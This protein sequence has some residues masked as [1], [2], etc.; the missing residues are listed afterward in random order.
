MFFHQ[1]WPFAVFASLLAV[2]LARLAITLNNFGLAWRYRSHTPDPYRLNAGRSL[3]MFCYEFYAS[4][5]SS[6]WAMPF[7]SFADGGVAHSKTLPV[8]LIHGYGCNSGYW[9]AMQKSLT[10]AGISHHAIDLEPVFGDIEEYVPLVHRAVETLCRD[11]GHNEIIIVAH[12]MGG[13]AARATMRV[14]GCTRIARLITLGTPHHGTA[15]ANYGVGM[16]CRQMHWRG[17][18][19]TGTPSHWLRKLDE[20]EPA[21]TR[22]RIVSIY[23]HH[24]NIVAP[25]TSSHLQGARNIEFDGIGHVALALHPRIHAC[26]IN[27]IRAVS[28]QQFPDVTVSEAAFA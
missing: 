16:N 11:S 12:S 25:Q 26:V 21:A 23:S 1:S 27:E 6:S 10:E 8:L 20:D 15:I 5:W 17:S 13:L 4:L 7:K 2:F 3:A 19:R 9:H 28:A 18:A 14:H 24:D 22:A